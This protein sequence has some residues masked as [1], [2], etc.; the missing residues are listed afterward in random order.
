MNRLAVVL[1]FGLLIGCATPT[2]V[3]PLQPSPLWSV[4]FT[5]PP[6]CTD[7]IIGE[8][9]KARE[10]VFVQAY[11]LTYKPIADALIAA[12]KRGVKVSVLLDTGQR[13]RSD[14]MAKPSQLKR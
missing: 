10:T 13:A 7:V 11:Y 5:P 4:C 14:S 9:T 6:G 2:P 8:L 3:V 1:L 12:H